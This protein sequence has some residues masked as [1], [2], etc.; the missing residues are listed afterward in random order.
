MSVLTALS[1]VSFEPATLK[2]VCLAKVPEMTI[3]Q[4]ANPFRLC[5]NSSRL[6]QYH[7]RLSNRES[8]LNRVAYCGCLLKANEIEKDFKAEDGEIQI[9]NTRLEIWF[10]SL[11]LLFEMQNVLKTF[12]QIFR[13]YFLTQC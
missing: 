6:L 2:F 11:C 10:G 12:Y 7:N 5:S 13:N 3:H 4:L 8:L 9:G 1:L